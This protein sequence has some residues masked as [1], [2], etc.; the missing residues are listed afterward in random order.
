MLNFLIFSYFEHL[1]FHAV[2][3]L[4][5]KKFHNFGPSILFETKAYIE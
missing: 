3:S 4:A 1:K 5:R 2:L